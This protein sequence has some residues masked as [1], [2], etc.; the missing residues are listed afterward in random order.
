MPNIF[1]SGFSNRETKKTLEISGAVDY[2]EKKALIVIKNLINHPPPKFTYWS[3][4]N[5]PRQ[6]GSMVLA[7]PL[8]LLVD[9]FPESL[10]YIMMLELSQLE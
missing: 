7:S 8:M 1:F 6:D 3:N 4:S 10:R 5:K 9:E 2:N